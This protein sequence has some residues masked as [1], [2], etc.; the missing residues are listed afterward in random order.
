[1][2]I[3]VDFFA[4]LFLKYVTHPTL[5]VKER[6]ESLFMSTAVD[7]YVKIKCS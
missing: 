1:M 4:K 7:K 2:T 3:K 6:T 5:M